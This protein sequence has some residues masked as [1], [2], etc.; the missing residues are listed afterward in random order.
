VSE[1]VSRVVCVVHNEMRSLV[2]L[3][4][5]PTV[6]SP[7]DSPLR[8]QNCV[9]LRRFEVVPVSARL[10]G[11]CCKGRSVKEGGLNV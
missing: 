10:Q 11:A 6:S 3:P 2:H 8:L 4:V 1:F 9:Q 7:R 5:N